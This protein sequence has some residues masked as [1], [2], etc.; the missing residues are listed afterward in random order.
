LSGLKINFHKSE[1]FVYGAAMDFQME[2]SQIFGCDVGTLPF[3]YLGI[4]M[5][6]RRLGNMDWKHVE[7]RI[8]KRLSGWKSKLLSVGGHLVLINS[9]LSSLPIFMLSFFGILNEVLKRLD[10]YRSRFFW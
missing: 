4:P 8:Q 6:H 5:W 3:C 1:L 7:E 10:F 2:F 9:V